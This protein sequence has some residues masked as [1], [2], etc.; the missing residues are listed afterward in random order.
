MEMVEI[1]AKSVSQLKQA[2][3]AVIAL[4]CPSQIV[5]PIGT[6]TPDQLRKELLAFN[7]TSATIATYQGYSLARMILKAETTHDKRVVIISN[8][9]TSTCH[10]PRPGEEDER[11]IVI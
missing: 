7:Q 9:Q 4:G 2:R 3:V 5:V 11:S 8:G 6:Y 1:V 10:A